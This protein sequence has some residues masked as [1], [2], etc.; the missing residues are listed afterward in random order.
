MYTHIHILICVCVCV[1]VSVNEL[2]RLLTLKNEHDAFES[3]R[4]LFFLFFLNQVS[5][6]MSERENR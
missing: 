6:N 2:T 4:F 5:F 1:C 3:M